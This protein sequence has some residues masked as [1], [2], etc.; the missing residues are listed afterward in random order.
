MWGGVKVGGTRGGGGEMMGI[1]FGGGKW[2]V[3]DETMYFRGQNSVPVI[4]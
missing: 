1:A 3:I 4:T 2:G